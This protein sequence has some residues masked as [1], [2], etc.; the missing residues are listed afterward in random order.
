MKRILRLSSPVD[1]ANSDA[2]AKR[3]GAERDELS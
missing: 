1:L 3:T 2:D